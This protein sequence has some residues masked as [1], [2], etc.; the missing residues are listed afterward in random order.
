[1][2][3]LLAFANPYRVVGDRRQQ[4]AGDE[5]RTGDAMPQQRSEVDESDGEK[6]GALSATASKSDVVEDPGWQTWRREN[7]R[8]QTGWTGND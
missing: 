1:L 4:P 7:N 3:A 6:A 5:G 2:L 8:S